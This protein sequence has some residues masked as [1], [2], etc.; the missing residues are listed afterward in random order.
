MKYNDNIA[1]VPSV[2]NNYNQNIFIKIA[3]EW[4]NHSIKLVNNDV[5][6]IIFWQPS[7]FDFEYAYVLNWNV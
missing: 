1:D 7:A 2:T 3:I 4:S 5:T 6:V